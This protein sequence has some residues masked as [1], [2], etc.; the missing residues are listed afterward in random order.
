MFQKLSNSWEL[1]K[2]SAQVLRAD[3]ELIVFPIVSGLALILVSATFVA[4][5]FLFGSGF[6]I[7]EEGASIL[8]Y[9]GLFVF[10]LVQYT[11]IFFFN[12]ALVGAAMIR[13][14][15]GDPTVG[16]GLRIA[17][18]HLGS[19]LGYAAIA[20][21]VGVI[22]K[23]ARERSGG[24]GKFIVGLVGMAWNLA[25]FLVVPVLVTQNVGPIE[26]IKRSASILKKTWGEQIVG[27]A[28]IGFVFGVLSFVTILLFVPIFI[29][30]VPTGNPWLIGA[31]ATTMVGVLLT[32]GL[33][34]ATL[35]GIYQAALYRFATGQESGR[36]DDQLLQG[37]FRPK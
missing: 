11:V 27:N 28:G 4:P 35:S 7:P 21:T 6:S 9:I 22:L 8:A 34:N 24:L 13:L 19:I 18:K 14:D 5:L 10:Y 36:F 26:A 12:S 16:D 32:L 29:L 1:V 30:T 2:A 31:A 15:G 23:T 33:L 25:T 3:K 17:F 37:A 20:A